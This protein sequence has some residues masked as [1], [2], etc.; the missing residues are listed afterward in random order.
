M[1]TY[2][3]A[4]NVRRLFAPSYFA[5][6]SNPY[7]FVRTLS[8]MGVDMV[9]EVRGR[10]RQIR[11]DVHPR[12]VE[13]RRGL[14][15]LLRAA[16]TTLLRDITVDTLITDVL[17]GDADVIYATFAAYDEVAHHAGVA[18]GD[19]LHVLSQLDRAFARIERAIDEA[20]RPYHVVVLSD[21]GQAQGATFKQRYG[22][23]LKELIQRLLPTE[24]RI[25]ERLQ[26]DED[27]GH[28]AALVSE[29][30]QQDSHM[31]GR[32]VRNVAPG[33]I[34]DG[35]VA[36][37]PEFQR[38]QEEREGRRIP[39]EDAQLIVLASGN[40]GL[41]YFTGWRKR[42]AL[43]EIE[44]HFPGLV[45]GL[46]RHPGIGFV[47]VRSERYGPLALGAHG[48]Y[49]L[50]QDRITGE[51]PLA[52][53]SPN[54]PMLLRR[55]DLYDN[56]P[57]LMINGFYDP[58]ADEGCAFEDLIGF[59]GG[60]GGDQNRPFLLVPVSWNLQNEMIVG[61]EQLHRLLKRRIEGLAF[62]G[63]ES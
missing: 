11:E 9:R 30:V 3:L 48:V 62:Y 41:V 24:L 1:L 34:E 45:D 37:G 5:F 58:V 31:I 57:D 19:A 13:R 52:S 6:F 25:H 61:A 14:Y 36:I 17:R 23:T 60:L 46:V 54:A 12:L 49:Y 28:V 16:T 22:I 53:F 40:L 2:S 33:R 47:L 38:L 7:N 10:R 50:A 63:D 8:L 43:E 55:I 56:I 20:D 15:P 18:D 59:H 4:T 21:H 51:N 39:S 32:F 35:E 42:L 26:T 44:A 29:V 27:W